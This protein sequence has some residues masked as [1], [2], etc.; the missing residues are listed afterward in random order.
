MNAL[1]NSSTSDSFGAAAGP[2]VVTP[3]AASEMLSCGITRL[4][5]LIAAGEIDS[6]TDG[7][8]R[9]IVVSSIRS[10]VQRRLATEKGRKKA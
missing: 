3:K 1:A 9:R 2:I 7:R 5:E 4:Y 6:Y 8:A 10:Y